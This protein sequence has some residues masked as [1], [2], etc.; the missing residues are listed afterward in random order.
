MRPR[1]KEGTEERGTIKLANTLKITNL[2]FL[3]PSFQIKNTENYIQYPI[4]QARNQA[5][6]L[7]FCRG[8]IKVVYE[9]KGVCCVYKVW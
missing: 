9:E 4:K 8:S 1:K 6:T 3:S 7:L 5:R 2:F